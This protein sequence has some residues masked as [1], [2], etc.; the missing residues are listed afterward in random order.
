MT[1][2]QNN[3]MF[4]YILLGFTFL[5]VSKETLAGRCTS[6]DTGDA[7]QVNDRCYWMIREHLIFNDAHKRCQED[8]GILAEIPDTE[9]Q[10]AVEGFFLSLSTNYWIGVHD[11]YRENY[12]VNMLNET[13]LYTKW[14]ASQP[15]NV[16]YKYKN[17]D[18]VEMASDGWVDVPCTLSMSAICSKRNNAHL[19]CLLKNSSEMLGG[20]Q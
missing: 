14:A 19:D 5:A 7:L 12:F 9:T 3:A 16:H 6:N 20:I 8:G 4:S 15:N 13:V 2:S 10:N 17:A 11:I 18:C 1:N